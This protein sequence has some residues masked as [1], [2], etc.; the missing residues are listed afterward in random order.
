MGFLKEIIGGSNE[1]KL[2][3][4]R[5]IAD[6]VIA[7]EDEFKELSDSELKTKTNE[8]RQRYQNGESLDDLLPEVF[9][10]VREASDRVLGMR[11]FYVQVIGG[12][13][14][15]QGRI[16]EMKT[17]EGKTLAATLAVCLNALTG[18]GVHV[19][20]VNDY[21]AKRDSEWMGKLYTYL[22]F[23]V[24]LIIHDIPPEERRRSYRCD[25]VYGTNNEFGFDYLRDN[26]VIQKEH[27]VQRELE[28]AV[29]DE[30]DSILIDEA[31][32][33]LIISG[34]GDKSTDMYVT[35][36]RFV[37]TLKLD[38]DFTID[39]KL[40][41][42]NLTEEGIAKS[43]RYFKVEN[44]ADIENTELNH[45][46]NQALKAN[47]IMKRDIDYVVKNGE[48]IIVD[49]FTGRLMIGRRYS[50]GLH[51]A[52]EAKENVK[53]E[54]ETRTL[55]TITFQNYF[56][57]YKKLSG[58]TGTAKTE[59]DEFQGIYNLDVVQ[60][61]TNKPMI[62]VDQNDVIYATEKGKFRAIVDEIARVHATGRPVLVGT[63]SV[64]KSER[65][66]DMLTRAGIKHNVLNAKHH[67]K[68]AMIVAQAGKKGAVTIATNM[69]GR[70]T[71][72]ILGGN[73]DFSAR[74]DMRMENYP[75]EMIEQA[76]SHAPTDDPEVLA[77]RKHYNELLEKYKKSMQ[78]EHDEVVALGG[79]HIIGTERHEARRIDNQ[80]RGRSGR[81]GDP[82]SSVFF[83]SLEDDLMRRFG[84]DRVQGLVA[85]VSQD[86]D[87]PLAFGLL[88]KQIEAAQKR[89]EYRNFEI[90][91]DVLQFDDVMNKQRE[92]IYSQRREVLMGADVKQAIMDMLD[93]IIDEVFPVFCPEGTLPEEWDIAGLSE[94]FNKIFLPRG[95][96]LFKGAEIEELTHDSAKEMIKELARKYYRAKEEEIEAAGQSMREIERILLL[97]AVDQ[98]WMAHID[99][100]DQLRQGIGLR[101]LGQKDPIIEYRREGFDMFEEMVREIQQDT[102]TMLFHVKITSRPQRSEAPKAVEPPKKM[103]DSAGRK[104]GRNSPCP[105][106]SGKKYKNCCGKE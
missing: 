39:E 74:G 20:T 28:F 71:D 10:Q 56:R 69:A 93:S 48:V 22:G 65:L 62:R 91:K 9:A 68:E 92:I 61:P 99:A 60:I 77:A 4:L 13:V 16:A 46:I 96:S 53:V 50:E 33:P 18:K 100:M 101:A 15:H 14:L 8:Y 6:A 103:V 73:P 70:G 27:M 106:G 102:V 54:R 88:T 1:S 11:H 37:K 38:E 59:E 26:M 17:G 94:Y 95:H 2:K 97:R 58:M 81:Q 19:V 86:D 83:I 35:V 34:P 84:G 78:T 12:I 75:E 87:I 41:A 64:E 32:T 43:E 98:K 23:T 52:I 76:V 3:K 36:D 51:Q 30:V 5:K 31:R 25:I 40:K 7:L 29:V 79:L 47:N 55:A 82:G 42:I 66:S 90:R 63:I 45:H 44:L 24:G 80:L 89:I 105:C 85:S 49:E 57:M 21:L 67:E 72:I 104:L